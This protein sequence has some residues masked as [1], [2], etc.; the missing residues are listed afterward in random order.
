MARN[1]VKQS[2]AIFT[3]SEKISQRISPTRIISLIQVGGSL[4]SLERVTLKMLKKDWT[5]SSGFQGR[6]PI[7]FPYQ[8]QDSLK[9]RWDWILMCCSRQSLF[10]IDER[11]FPDFFPGIIWFDFFI[12]FDSFLFL[13]GP[14][15]L[16][17]TAV[18]ERGNAPTNGSLFH[19][20]HSVIIHIIAS[21]FS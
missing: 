1:F 8:V 9:T 15:I 20:M 10:G 6:I 11:Y 2:P 5:N 21:P 18:D 17:R 7:D 13:F 4:K 12:C 14:V 16:A 19:R 3:N